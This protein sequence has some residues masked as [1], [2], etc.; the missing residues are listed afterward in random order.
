VNI[1]AQKVV[2]DVTKDWKINAL[3]TTFG[4]RTETDLDGNHS[5]TDTTIDVTDG[6]GFVAGDRIMIYGD[7]TNGEFHQ[8]YL[9]VTSVSSDE[10]TIDEGLVYGYVDETPVKKI[11]R[12][13]SFDFNRVVVSTTVT[14]KIVATDSLDAIEL[15]GKL[16][17][18]AIGGGSI[19]VQVG[20]EM[21]QTNMGV[22]KISITRTPEGEGTP[23][24]FDVIVN[25]TN[26]GV[27]RGEK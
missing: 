18:M 9:D 10:L 25:L 24:Q 20:D 3:P 7:D 5:A 13:V 1:D 11:G 17:A 27:E 14:G 6:S 8:E 16:L 21:A 12:V 4:N 15:K 26:C 23:T 2:D 19:Q 22:T